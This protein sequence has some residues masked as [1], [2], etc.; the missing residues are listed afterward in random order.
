M[1]KG[2]GKKKKHHLC[3]DPICRAQTKTSAAC[4]RH[5]NALRIRLRLF[6]KGQ[7]VNESV[8]HSW[9][10]TWCKW[11]IVNLNF[12]T[13]YQVCLKCM[14]PC[15]SPPIN[16]TKLYIISAN[17]WMK[18]DSPFVGR[19]PWIPFLFKK[20]KKKSVL[21]LPLMHSCAFLRAVRNQDYLHNLSSFAHNI[22]ALLTPDCH[23]S[24]LR[25]LR[26]GAKTFLRAS[27]YLSCTIKE[28][29]TCSCHQSYTA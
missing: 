15:K 19:T 4:Q 17:L 3:P 10:H 8:R 11:G 25:Q 12:K 26:N 7:F 21:D 6:Q 28:A 16:K 24:Q 2:E 18:R 5:V 27:M 9:A 13:G 1:G 20:K 23:V 29:K 22:W 14:N